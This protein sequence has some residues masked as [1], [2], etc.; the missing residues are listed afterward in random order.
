MRPLTTYWI[1]CHQPI[2]SLECLALRW[3]QRVLFTEQS[4]TRTSTL[5]QRGF[6]PGPCLSEGSFQD[7]RASCPGQ[8][9]Y[10]IC[11]N[12]VKC[13]HV[14]FWFQVMFSVFRGPK[15]DDIRPNH[16][17]KSKNTQKKPKNAK[18]QKKTQNCTTLDCNAQQWNASITHPRWVWYDP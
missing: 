6:S 13:V 8:H 5:F 2:A 17:K 7:S 18:M 3:G 1:H 15:Y 9:V 10:C 12:V 16:T 11:C 14:L 4:W